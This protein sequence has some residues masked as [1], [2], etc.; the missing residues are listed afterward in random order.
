MTAP[1]TWPEI[2]TYAG[3]DSELDRPGPRSINM[4]AKQMCL[5]AMRTVLFPGLIDLTPEAVTS[6]LK[7]GHCWCIDGEW[8]GKPHRLC[9]KCGDRYAVDP[10][11]A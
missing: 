10:V 6:L 2:G 5:E 3:V 4:A 1:N 8:P 7:A 9:C 11:T